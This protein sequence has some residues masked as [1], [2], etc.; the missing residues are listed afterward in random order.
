MVTSVIEA[1]QEP[2]PWFIL[3]T[4]GIPLACV[5]VGLIRIVRLLVTKQHPRGI[6][7]WWLLA[8]GLAWLAMSFLFLGP[9]FH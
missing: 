5:A 4:I 7:D 9:L 3:L 1:L 6:S 2:E 8:A